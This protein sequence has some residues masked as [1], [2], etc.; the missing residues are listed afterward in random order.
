MIKV[1]N[2]GLV[3][4]TA[5]E[6]DIVPM[7]FDAEGHL[8]PAGRAQF[9]FELISG[10]VQSCVGPTIGTPPAGY[11]V[12]TITVAASKWIHTAQPALEDGGRFNIR[13]KGV[14]T[15]RVTW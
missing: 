8:V 13:F 7:D 6:Q 2:G 4:S 5:I 14:A 15:V 1:L 9:M 12:D 3:T 11:T 10:S